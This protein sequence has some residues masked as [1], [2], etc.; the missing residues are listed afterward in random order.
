MQQIQQLYLEFLQNFPSGIQPIISI[1]LA[2]LVV[3]SVIK[4]IKKQFIFLIVLV[5]LLPGSVP[6][7]KSIW[8]GI[9]TFIK[10]LLNK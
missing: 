6:I 7:L 1:G 9:V 4:V 5:V 8:E 3:F 10:F 2:V